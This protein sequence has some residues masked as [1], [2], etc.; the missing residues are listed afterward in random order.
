MLN[1][2]LERHGDLGTKAAW[3]AGKK[4]GRIHSVKTPDGIFPSKVQCA[5]FYGKSVFWLLRTLRI[6]KEGWEVL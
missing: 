6:G 1:L 5:K 2:L 3:A 4:A